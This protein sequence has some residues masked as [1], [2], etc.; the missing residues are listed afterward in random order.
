VTQAARN[1]VLAK[2]V[3]MKYLISA[4]SILCLAAVS[5]ALHGQT[6]VR[7]SQESAPGAGDFDANVLG[8]IQPFSLPAQTA[9]TVYQYG[10]PIGAS[11]NGTVITAE[12]SKSK[13]F[14]VETSNGLSLFVV[15]DR[16]ND[17]S[18]GRAEMRFE[19]SGDT[20]GAARIVEDDPQSPNDIGRA[21]NLFGPTVFQTVHEWVECCTDGV[22]IGALNG[23]WSMLVQFRNN[24]GVAIPLRGIDSWEATSAN[25][26]NVALNLQLERRI[27]LDA[28]VRVTI[29]IKPGTYPNSV[30]LG[31]NGVVPVA[32]LSTSTFDASTVDPLTVTLAGA[33]VQLKGKGTPMSSLQDVSGD[34]LPDLIVHVNT[35]ALQ[36][37]NTDVTAVLAGATYSGVPIV[38]E[39]TIRVVP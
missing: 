16:P 4:T 31:S 22:V 29:D 6:T 38:G 30:N 33:S 13:L 15:H 34:G 12:S 25:G 10:S 19:L 32:I 7:V 8:S 24:S 1:A 18:G 11:Y 14:L 21:G 28:V 35:E 37:T 39:D 27:R 20:D 23:P 26:S 3:S 9:S 17:G 2:G 5:P 36:L